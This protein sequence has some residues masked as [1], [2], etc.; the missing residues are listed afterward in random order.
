MAL[1]VSRADVW[2]G[3]IQDQP[4]GLARVLDAVADAGGNLDCVIAR[5][6]QSRPGTG[7]VFVTPVEGSAAQGAARAAGL[8]P[9]QNIATLRVEGADAPGLGAQI[10]E[11]LRDAGI[12]LRGVSAAVVGRNFVSYIGLDTPGDADAAVAALRQVRT[13]GGGG[14]TKR[15]SAGKSRAT[16]KRAGTA[17]RA[18]AA[19]K[20]GRATTAKRATGRRR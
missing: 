1:K 15:A 6:E 8:S 5:R 10:A 16:A 19:A 7:V 4:G 20:R 3:E 14:R 9:A 13:G 18:S 2:A 12:N 17:K 11:A